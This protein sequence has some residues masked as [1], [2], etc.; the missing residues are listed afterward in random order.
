MSNNDWTV[1]LLLNTSNNKTYVGI[2][3]NIDKRIKQHNGILKGGAKFTRAF[4]G[5]GEWILLTS[6]NNLNKIRASKMEYQI[7]NSKTIIKNGNS[8][9]RRLK[10]F[11]DFK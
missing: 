5:D 4:K 9:E 2:T 8:V 6:I 10:I 3:N 11:N 7:K 1:Y